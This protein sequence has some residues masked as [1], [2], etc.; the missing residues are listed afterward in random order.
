MKVI[1]GSDHAG[2]EAK[3]R[4]AAFLRKMGH[5][6]E[7]AGTE[8]KDP[9]DYPDF[10]VQVG[11]TVAEGDADR[12]VLICGTGIGMSITANKIAGVRAAMATDE[13]TA[14]MG[15][16]HNDAN[17]L[18]LGAR[19][20]TPERMENLI[21]IFMATAFE[22]GRHVDRVNKIKQLDQGKKVTDT[23]E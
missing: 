20:L 17:V 13:M 22:G 12:G 4:L 16:K 23:E 15:R 21:R 2:F 8:G 3:Q 9:V 14:E 7:D 18:C 5:T 6:L 19:V 1:I 11:R 10:A